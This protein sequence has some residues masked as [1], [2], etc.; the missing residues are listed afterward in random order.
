MYNY[1]VGGVL[2][3]RKEQFIA[4][5]GWSYLYWGWGVS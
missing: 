5:N 2:A 1:L 3:F 4:V